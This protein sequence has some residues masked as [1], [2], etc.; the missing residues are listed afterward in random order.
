MR[1]YLIPF[2]LFLFLYT[3]CKK[4]Y[5]C[6]KCIPITP[7][8]VSTDSITNIVTNS[9]KFHGTLLKIGDTAVSDYGFCW[10]TTSSPTI[11]SSKVSNGATSNTQS[12]S[13]IVTGLL[14]NRLYYV[15]A[16]AINTKGTVYGQELSFKTSSNPLLDCLVAYYPFKGDTKDSSSNMN[17]ATSNGGTFTSDK[18]GTANNAYNFNGSNHLLIN[19]SSSISSITNSVTIAAWVYN[20]N[21]EA[22]VV[23][24]AAF[25]GPTMQFRLYA[26]AGGIHFVNYGKAVDFT[27]ILIPVNTWKHIVVTCDGTTA[28]CYLN[29]SLVSTQPLHIDNSANDNT[30]DMYIGADTHN[31]TEFHSGKLDEIRI[32]CRV[33]S[34]TEVQQLFSL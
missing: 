26:D 7:P 11:N 4:E 32:Y 22:Y 31:V 3:S 13:S 34:A 8:V 23:C 21:P 27:N 33:L 16:Y 12:Y 29:G 24:K 25:N 19:N 5:S 10:A 18:N 9:A 6:E 30:T 20:E 14:E 28:K 17:H 15:R 1:K 2:S